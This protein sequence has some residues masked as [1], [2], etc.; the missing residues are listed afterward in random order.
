MRATQ[1][2]NETRDRS[3][4]LEAMRHE[5]GGGQHGFVPAVQTTHHNRTTARIRGSSLLGLPRRRSFRLGRFYHAT[6]AA[7]TPL[8]HGRH[9]DTNGIGIES[10][11][12]RGSWQGQPRQRLRLSKGSAS[13]ECEV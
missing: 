9:I 13:R 4:R 3:V 11:R 2:P 1:P 7:G 6:C 8:D 5:L 10:A 12:R